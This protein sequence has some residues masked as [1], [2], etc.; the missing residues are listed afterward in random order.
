MPTP[1]ISIKRQLMS[2]KDS[3]FDEWVVQ[4]RR[5]VQYADQVSEPVLTNTLPAFYDHLVRLTCS[6]PSIFDRSTIASEHG[7]ER[8]RLTRFNAE[9]IIHELHLFRASVFSVWERNGIAL[10]A[11]QI[12]D[13]TDLIDTALRDSVTG[14]VL[15]ETTL[16]EQFFS[17]LTHDLRT[18]LGTAS[19]AIEMIRN[20]DASDR[21]HRLATV[22][23]K[24][25]E[26]MSQMITGLLDMMVLKDTNSQTLE[27]EEVELRGIVEQVVEDASL[28]TGRSIV[29]K[30]EHVL[31]FWNPQ[32]LRRAIEN[33]LN[34][35]VK[36]SRP[37]TPI[38]VTLE[39]YRGRAILTVCNVGEPIPSDQLEAIFQLFRR[40][41]RTKKNGPAG[42]GIGLPYVRSVAE[43][44]A[45]SIAVESG[46]DATRFTLDIPID[47]RPI[48]AAVPSQIIPEH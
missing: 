7:A 42:W 38:T 25:H 1:L 41:E 27:V 5:D 34:N 35:A 8:A 45:G 30:A 20:M 6:E 33:L 13:I 26:L 21:V 4:V 15:M 16:R 22:A 11:A 46:D 14:F 3:V 19:M 28:S 10:T 47:P 2:L 37:A 40:A 29:I 23:S 17:A 44:H 9:S 24:Q 43:R 18:P 39:G 32:A 12:R 36:Y 48:L 31:G